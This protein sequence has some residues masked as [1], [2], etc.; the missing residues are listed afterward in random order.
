MI[1]PNMATMLGFITTDANIESKCLHKVL[2]KAVN[3]S[4]NM[5]SVDGDTST[6]DM[7]VI[8][9]NGL[10]ENPQLTLQSDELPLFEDALTQVCI[11]LA[12]KIAADGEGSH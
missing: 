8:L 6:N 7:V 2:Q 3:A 9:A 5:I 12:K 4:F 1:H 11:D 10:A